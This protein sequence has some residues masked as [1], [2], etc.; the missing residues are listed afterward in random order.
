M[1]RPSDKS[2]GVFIMNRS[3]YE[4]EVHDELKENG[5]YKES[6]E[7]LTTRIQNKIKKNVE[8]MYKINVFTKEMKEYLIPKG[9]QPGKVQAYPKIHKRKHQLRTNVNGNN[10]ATENMAEI[11]EHELMEKV[12]NL[13]SYIKDTTEFLQKNK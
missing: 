12:C 5:T 1:I 2:S 13:K 9:S 4:P 11:V 10:H 7:D 3:D 8:G 6:K